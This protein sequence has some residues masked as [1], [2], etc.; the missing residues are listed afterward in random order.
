LVF[1]KFLS[2]TPFVSLIQTMLK[3]L[4]QAYNYPVDIEFTVNFQEDEGFHI[5]LLQCRP[6][7]VKGLHKNIS[8]P[9]GTDE[10][11]V[12]FK[13]AGNFMGGSISQ[14]IDIFVLVVPEEYSSLDIAQKYEVA[15]MV[16]K[17][18]RLTG[19]KGSASLLMAGPGRWGTSTP[20]LGVP[21]TFSEINNSSVLVEIE[22][23]SAGLTPELSFGTHFFQDLVETDVFYAAVFPERDNV[24][25]NMERLMKLPNKLSELFPDKARL[26]RVLKVYDVKGKG[27]TMMADI[28]S[29]K[30]LCHFT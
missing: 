14:V 24:V 27:L 20:S 22:F 4:E 19:S 17:L 25:C 26:D 11:N 8:I 16:G 9:S 29:Q 6:L 23:A 1:E 7:Q 30:L 3:A 28:I 13:S 5:N 18:N 12:V 15:R 10:G 2:H 21:V